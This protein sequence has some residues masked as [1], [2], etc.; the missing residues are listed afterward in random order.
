MRPT[1]CLFTDSLEPS[2]VGEHMLSLA[3]EL[4]GRYRMS[5]VCPPTPAGLPLLER[6]A[7]MDVETLALEEERGEAHRRRLGDWFR[8]RAVDVF[9]GHAGIAWEGH[10]GIYAAR[11]AG[12][13]AVLRTEHLPYLL[14]DSGQR[15]DHR[16]LV[17][18]VDRLVCVSRHQYSTFVAA[19][20]PTASLRVVR[21]GINPALS[22]PHQREVRRR[23][24]V[25][26]DARLILT[27]GRLT[28][29]KGH[30][31]LAEAAPTVVGRA[32]DVH[33]V[34]VGEGILEGE[35]R[36]RVRQLGMEGHVSFLGRRADAAEILAASALFVLP[37][38]F[39]GLPLV[40]LEAMAAGV[41]VVGTRGCGTAEAVADRVTGRLVD[42]G[43]AA[44]LAEAILD[45][46][47]APIRARRWGE[48]GRQRFEREFRASRMAAETAA[49]YGELLAGGTRPSDGSFEL[50]ASGSHG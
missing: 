20:V 25:S 11:D 49:V 27:T 50:S 3:G 48:A 6:A 18:A 21:N 15:E 30:R 13:P 35:L 17:R 10:D 5:F 46:L 14:T 12:V 16:R 36:A 19:G 32:P 40:V 8:A 9:H 47:E 1:V 45:V 7:A 28:E 22:R 38:L 37:S 33:F 39:E 26:S 24:G 42:P 4:H 34:W 31:Y 29:Q 44:V 43:D 41:P 2:G 23:L